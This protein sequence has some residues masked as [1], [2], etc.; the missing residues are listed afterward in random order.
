MHSAERELQAACW[1]T[2]QGALLSREDS[3]PYIYL[4]VLVEDVFDY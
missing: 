1:N 2:T 4:V 3:L